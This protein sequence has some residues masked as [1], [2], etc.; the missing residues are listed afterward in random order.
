MK[1]SLHRI[2]VRTVRNLKNCEG[3]TLKDGYVIQYKTGWQVAS[4]GVKCFSAEEAMKY[5]RWFSKNA[6]QVGHNVGIWLSD[7]VYYVDVCQ[8]IPTKRKAVEEGRRYNQLSIYYWGQ[9]KESL[10]WL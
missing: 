6:K 7:G 4:M 2:N 8:R 10:E 3:I 1:K 5:T 9:R